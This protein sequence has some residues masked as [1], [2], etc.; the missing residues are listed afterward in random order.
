MSI[1]L[2]AF[3][4]TLSTVFYHI[5]QKMTPAAANP[6]LALSVTYGVALCLTFIMFSF[7]PLGGF[8][9]ALQKLN[10]VSFALGLAIVGLEVATLLAY[11]AG[12][13]LS[14]LSIVVN[15]VASLVLVILGLV[16]YKEKLTL[17]NIMGIL[18]CI[19]GLAMINYKR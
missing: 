10:W 19:A 7:F 5:F 3:L 15:V 12:W 16:L 8:S 2:T 4:A 1:I 17:V 6:A 18:V 9:A 13:E 11:R 14:L